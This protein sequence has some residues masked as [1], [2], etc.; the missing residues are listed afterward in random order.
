[1]SSRRPRKAQRAPPDLY[2]RYGVPEGI[3]D[4]AAFT[5]QV[6]DVLA[7][8]RE[9]KGRRMYARLAETL[10]AAHAELERA[11]RLTL[12]NFAERNAEARRA[13]LE[14]L[15]RLAGRGRRSDSRRARHC[16]PAAR[17]PRRRGH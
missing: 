2:A 17:R 5:R 3:A 4:Q 6:A 1:M 13:Q 14:R 11:G 12:K 16:H 7:F 10:I 15:T 9:L 8:W